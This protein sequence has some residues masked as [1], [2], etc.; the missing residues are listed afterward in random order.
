M[1]QN[2]NVE[3]TL[4]KVSQSAVRILAWN[5]FCILVSLSVSHHTLI[6]TTGKKT[7]LMVLLNADLST[8]PKYSYTQ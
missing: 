6:F 7:H 3:S 2:D 5:L 1:F 8:K 4:E